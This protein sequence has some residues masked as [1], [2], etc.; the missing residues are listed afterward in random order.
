MKNLI[1]TILLL[2]LPI[3]VQAN[4]T[5]FDELWGHT[6]NVLDSLPVDSSTPTLNPLSRQIDLSETDI[7]GP[8]PFGRV[9]RSSLTLGL[10]QASLS[11]SD[12]ASLAYYTQGRYSVGMGSGWRHQYSFR[13]YKNGTGIGIRAPSDLYPSWY[14]LSGSSVTNQMTGK[15]AGTYTAAGTDS[16]GNPTPETIEIRQGS[17]SLVL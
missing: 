16:Q 13:V 15:T 14:T 4:P 7:K 2:L 6:A 1:T 8:L 9:Y 3:L 17:G 11:D 10:D 12:S 5:A